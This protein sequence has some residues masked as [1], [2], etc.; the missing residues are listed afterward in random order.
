MH[1]ENMKLITTII[2]NLIFSYFSFIVGRDGSVGMT[3]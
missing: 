2:Y 3:C 1:G